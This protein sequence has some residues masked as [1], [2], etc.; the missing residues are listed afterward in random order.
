MPK[1]NNE[2]IPDPT[3]YTERFRNR[4]RAIR[5]FESKYNKNRTSAEKIADAITSFCGSIEFLVLNTLW[6]ILWIVLNTGIIPG[7]LPFDPFPFGLLTMIVSLEAIFL[8]IFVLISQN[9]QSK[10]DDLRAEIDMHVNMV[11]EEEITKIMH[12][13]Y[14]LY[15]G[16]KLDMAHD[17]ELD[18]MM[19][20]LD[21]NLIEKRL[22]E[23]M[24][25]DE[26]VFGALKG[27]VSR[28]QL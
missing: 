14:G 27:M 23:Q 3:G 9:R 6:F 18:Q 16:L 4:R 11:A 1:T 22:E 8:S 21:R 7:I 2:P 10:V 13:V 12:M 26:T 19:K 5:T 28:K 17:P 24:K 15:K 20:P 25:G